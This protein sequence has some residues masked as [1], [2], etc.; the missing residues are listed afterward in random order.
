MLF[1]SRCSG[2]CFF[3]ISLDIVLEKHLSPSVSIPLLGILFFLPAYWL[4][5][6][7]S[8]SGSINVSIPLLGILFFLLHLDWLLLIQL[9]ALWFQSRCSGFCFFYLMVGTAVL[10][11]GTLFQ[12]RC[13]GFCF[14]YTPKRDPNKT[15]KFQL[16]SIPLLGI[17]FFL[18][19]EKLGQKTESWCFNPVAR[20]F[21]FST[22]KKKKAH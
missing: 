4:A 22:S 11:V 20:D 8:N 14:F 9:S 1:Q 6:L 19:Y 2:F 15:Q 16:V 17:L 21:V 3:Y 13:S 18:R 10:T 5:V 12:S 7:A